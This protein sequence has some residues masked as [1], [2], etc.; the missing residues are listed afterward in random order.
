MGKLM[1]IDKDIILQTTECNLDFGCL[2]GKDHQC[3]D[4]IVE[5]SVGN[6][7]LFMDCR[8]INCNYKSRFAG[9]DV[10]NCPVRREIYNKYRR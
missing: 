7:I 6:D 8:N 5:K 2:K 3:L 9:I 4:S 10:C 1:E